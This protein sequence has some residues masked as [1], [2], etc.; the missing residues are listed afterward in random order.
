MISKRQTMLI[1]SCLP[2]LRPSFLFTFHIEIFLYCST[3][4]RWF[5]DDVSIFGARLGGDTVTAAASATSVPPDQSPLLLQG[6][7]N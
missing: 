2:Y 4:T 3:C 1:V 5:C 6:S 7:E